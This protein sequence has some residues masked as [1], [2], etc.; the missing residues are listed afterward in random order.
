MNMALTCDNEVDD[1]ESAGYDPIVRLHTKRASL[2]SYRGTPK[3]RSTLHPTRMRRPQPGTTDLSQPLYGAGIGDAVKRFFKKYA[4]FSGRASRS[5]YWRWMLANFVVI[6]VLSTWTGIAAAGSVDPQTGALAS[7]GFMVP[8]ALTMIWSLAILIP[9][10][11]LLV[12]RLH[13]AGFS[14]WMALLGLIPIVGG[15]VIL[16]FSLLPSKPEGARFDAGAQQ[17]GAYPQ[18]PHQS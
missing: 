18:P 4:T 11:A 5:E 12:R 7:P 1:S 8:Y 13:D 6:S 2:I 16:V 15:L 10:I 3:C 17:Y 14:G 9:G